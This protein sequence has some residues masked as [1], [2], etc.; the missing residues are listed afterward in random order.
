MAKWG[1]Q[2]G[3]KE[4]NAVAW[5]GIPAKAQLQKGEGPHKRGTLSKIGKKAN[6]RGQNNRNKTVKPWGGIVTEEKSEKLWYEKIGGGTTDR[7]C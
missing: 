3:E 5:R 7:C 4:H 2:I 1:G 6:L